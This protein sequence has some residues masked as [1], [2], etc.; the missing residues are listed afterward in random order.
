MVEHISHEA[1]RK[2][3]RDRVSSMCFMGKPPVT[4]LPP[5]GLRLLVVAPQAVD[6]ACGRHMVLARTL[7]K[8]WHGF[9]SLFCLLFSSGWWHSRLLTG[10]LAIHLSTP[11]TR[12]IK[13]LV[14]PLVIELV[15]FLLM[16]FEAFKKASHI[17]TVSSLGFLLCKQ[18]LVMQSFLTW[19]SPTRPF[20][21]GKA[22]TSEAMSPISSRMPLEIM[23]S[24]SLAWVRC[25]PLFVA[26]AR[27]C[28]V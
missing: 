10:F 15:V 25:R 14:C 20:Q 3:G 22:D 27:Q 11:V 7:T 5:S 6:Q 1:T 8:R 24:V 19:S 26:R 23:N 16:S 21:R 17:D 9:S 28:C 12:P 2:T 13:S 18:M 4:S